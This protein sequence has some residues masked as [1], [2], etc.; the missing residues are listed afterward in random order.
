MSIRIRWRRSDSSPM[1]V[2]NLASPN[3]RRRTVVLPAIVIGILLSS[4]TVLTA[5]RAAFSAQTANEGNQVSV[6]DVALV[7]DDAGSAMFEVTDMAPGDVITTCI[8]VTYEGSIADPQAVRLYSGGYTDSGALADALSLTVEQGTGGSFADC[9]GFSGAQIYDG[10]LAGFD[11]THPDYAS[12]AG[13]W[14]PNSTPESQTYRFTIELPEDADNSLQGTSVTDLV[15][16][17]EV[18]S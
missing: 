14:D 18:Q 1:S 5:S 8:E 2:E 16:V 4:V 11:A 7:D 12:G 13:T 3:D 9:T 17:W 6:G 10:T 15:F